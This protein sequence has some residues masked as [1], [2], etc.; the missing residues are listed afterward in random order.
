MRSAGHEVVPTREPFVVG[1]SSLLGP[2]VRLAPELVQAN[3][4]GRAPGTDWR[5]GN[6]S[7]AGTTARA[8]MEM[9]RIEGLVFRAHVARASSIGLSGATI[10]VR[11]TRAARHSASPSFAEQA[12]R[13]A[14]AA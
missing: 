8:E 6:V 13:P 4:M 2:D 12:Y 3:R 1:L 14:L 10:P 7:R 9:P 11:A 5:V